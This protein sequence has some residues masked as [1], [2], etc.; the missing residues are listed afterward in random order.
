MASYVLILYDHSIFNP[1]KYSCPL[2]NQGSYFGY[3][4]VFLGCPGLLGYHIFPSVNDH[5]HEHLP[6]Q[7]LDSLHNAEKVR[8]FGCQKRDTNLVKFRGI[9]D[10]TIS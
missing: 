9:T 7:I 10:H 1:E 3:T 5:F 2:G 4:V 8:N 6:A